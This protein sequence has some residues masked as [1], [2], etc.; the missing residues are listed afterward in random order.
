MTFEEKVR[1]R[2]EYLIKRSLI[3][4]KDAFLRECEL[5]GKFLIKNAKN[6]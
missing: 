4:N 5:F 3:K 2:C 6:E 1:R